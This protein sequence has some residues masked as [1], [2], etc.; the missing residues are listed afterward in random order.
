MRPSSSA[1]NELAMAFYSPL[2][3]KKEHETDRFVSPWFLPQGEKK[4]A[5]SLN[6]Y[7][8]GKWR[9]QEIKYVPLPVSRQKI[10]TLLLTRTFVAFFLSHWLLKVKQLP[11]TT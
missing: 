3:R 6:V 11:T 9:G 4:L 2:F 1:S 5:I 10:D 7:N 8:G